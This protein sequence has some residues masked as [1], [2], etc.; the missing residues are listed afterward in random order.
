MP[1]IDSGLNANSYSDLN[2]HIGRL[3]HFFE[4]GEIWRVY[5]A[6][7]TERLIKQENLRVLPSEVPL[8][9]EELKFEPGRMAMVQ[10][11]E[12]SE[13]E[14]DASRGKICERICNHWGH[15]LASCAPRKCRPLIIRSFGN[16]CYCCRRKAFKASLPPL[17][18]AEQHRRD[19]LRVKITNR[20][21]ELHEKR[22]ET[23]EL[24]I[25]LEE[26]KE[27]VSALRDS[28]NRSQLP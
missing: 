7:G 14:K 22:K 20:Q 17:S 11:I 26:L 2:G 25:K 28:V 18:K 8:P 21:I 27:H 12:D 9:D 5:M 15:L 4:Q 13:E 1:E 10:G 23:A 19:R 6:D 3:K 24:E 16:C